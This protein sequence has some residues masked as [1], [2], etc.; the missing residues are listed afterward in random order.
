MGAK[1]CNGP[2]RKLFFS[3]GQKATLALPAVDLDE[4]MEKGDQ[5]TDEEVI[6]LEI[7]RILLYRVFKQRPEYLVE[8]TGLDASFNMWIHKDVLEQDVPNMVQAYEA[9]QE[10]HG[11]QTDIA[12]SRHVLHFAVQGSRADLDIS[13]AEMDHFITAYVQKFSAVKALEMQ[14]NFRAEMLTR[15]EGNNEHS[16]HLVGTQAMEGAQE[17]VW[18]AEI[19]AANHQSLVLR[20][21]LFLTRG[22][23]K[24]VYSVQAWWRQQVRCSQI[25][26]GQTQVLHGC[27]KAPHGKLKVLTV[28]Q[29]E[30]RE[31]D[32]SLQ[33][34]IGALQDHLDKTPAVGHEEILAVQRETSVLSSHEVAL[35]E[36]GSYHAGLYEAST[37]RVK[38]LEE[39]IVTLKANAAAASNHVPLFQELQSAS[40]GYKSALAAEIRA[41]EE[42]EQTVKG[43]RAVA[44]SLHHDHQLL[45]AAAA[46][47]EEDLSA[48]FERLKGERQ[49]WQEQEKDLRASLR[50]VVLC[51]EEM[52]VWHNERLERRENVNRQ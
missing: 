31:K 7:K 27:R 16:S 24:P 40:E 50:E 2:A 30:W 3:D 11:F 18:S 52:S 21:V 44:H 51:A 37:A 9:L 1:N 38:E 48:C 10:L 42:L 28:G 4:T 6:V 46:G 35:L 15:P 36:A 49:L 39:E 12:A 32:P 34:E 14:A 43:W 19:R 29:D 13:D 25:K 8:W 45:K 22:I 41:V 33:H 20:A 26:A 5:I 17:S 23:T 47:R